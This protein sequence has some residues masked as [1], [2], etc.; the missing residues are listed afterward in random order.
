[1]KKLFGYIFLVLAGLLVLTALNTLDRMTMD[2]AKFLAIFSGSLSAYEAGEAIGGLLAQLML[3]LV[4]I[5]LWK[6]G[7]K[8]TK[9]TE[10]ES[11]KP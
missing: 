2:V 4:I 3:I 11:D 8:W 1:M 7:R 6:Y 10:V 9:K 5:L